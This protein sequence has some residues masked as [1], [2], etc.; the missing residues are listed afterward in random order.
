MG[1]GRETAKATRMLPSLYAT[2]TR[3]YAKQVL[4]CNYSVESCT[5]R[6]R[7]AS[8]LQTP[9]FRGASRSCCTNLETGS[10]MRGILYL[11]SYCL[12]NCP[13][14]S[15]NV[16]GGTRGSF[17]L[18][19]TVGTVGHRGRTCSRESFSRSARPQEGEEGVFPR[20]NSGF[21]TESRPWQARRYPG[22]TSRRVV[23]NTSAAHLG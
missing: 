21:P 1:L 13:R 16:R 10:G 12:E 11:L 15:K 6:R 14:G 17:Q 20:A 9:R 23:Y 2:T 5:W 3:A 22:H 8:R 19:G 18:V 7:L 4:L